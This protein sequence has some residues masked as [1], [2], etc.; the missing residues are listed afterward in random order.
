MHHNEVSPQILHNTSG[1]PPSAHYAC[2]LHVEH[3]EVLQFRRERSAEQVDD[4]DSRVLKRL[5]I[6]QR[7]VREWGRCL[8]LYEFRL[9]TVIVDETVGRQKLSYT[10]T[11]HRLIEG[12]AGCAGTGMCRRRVFYALKS[13]TER[14][15]IRKTNKRNHLELA[16]NLNWT[17][18][19]D[20]MIPTPKRLKNP[21][22][23][24]EAPENPGEGVHDMHR[25][26]ALDALQG[27]TSCTLY[28]G[29]LT[30]VSS[31][32]IRS[33]GPDA[34]RPE[35]PENFLSG[36]NETHLSG[37]EDQLSPQSPPDQ[38][39]GQGDLALPVTDPALLLRKR[40]K[41]IV[42]DG[43][44]RRAAGAQRA[45]QQ[46]RPGAVEIV[47]RTAMQETFP[48][49][50]IS[51][52]TRKDLGRVG[53]KLKGFTLPEGMT[54]PAFADWSVR[55][56]TQI[57]S[58]QFRWMKKSSPP[59]M[60]DLS[61]W[62]HFAR[63]FADCHAEGKLRSWLRSGEASE[64]QKL[65]GRGMTEEQALAE[66]GRQRAARG[67][68]DEMTKREQKVKIK[69]SAAKRDAQKAEA[70]AQFG[71]KHGGARVIHPRSPNAQKMAEEMRA[72]ERETNRETTGQSD[73]VLQ[74]VAPGEPMPIWEELQAQRAK[75]RGET[76]E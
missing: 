62:L 53:Q 39:E 67:M 15:L 32:Q 65:M 24:D 33:S 8:D 3:S 64:L 17:G 56:W 1:L 4:T 31:T 48:Q 10:T 6:Y 12:N 50:T 27:C 45:M 35:P 54:F 13:L 69:A 58:K 76:K 22:S 41:K 38:P 73:P 72:K 34:S 60:P 28:T 52:W 63:Q 68:R 51:A 7:L 46:N 61:F 5:K 42:D 16:P 9:M 47:W 66:I 21:K 20:A 57:M 11:V 26:G 59:A 37:H 14:G 25:R 18:E 29:I 71:A 43:K 36:E 55:N 70:F 40:V 19:D 23:G 44:A 74:P 30:H 2:G 49:A 75:A